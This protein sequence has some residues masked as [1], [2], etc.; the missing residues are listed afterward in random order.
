MMRVVS[1]LALVLFLCAPLRAQDGADKTLRGVMQSVADQ[2]GAPVQAIRSLA[3]G[4]ITK[5]YARPGQLV[6]AGEILAELDY[7]QQLYQRNTAKAQMDSEGGMQSAEGQ[8]SQRKAELE[9]ARDLLKKRVIAEYR[10]ASAEAWV[11]WAEGQ[12]KSI[13]EQK[14]QQK[15]AYE[16]WATEYEKRFIRAPLDGVITELKVSEGQGIG[17]AAHVFTQNNPSAMQLS[18]SVVAAQ[19]GN[20]NVNDKLLVRPPG[21]GKLMQAVVQ[22]VI[23]DPADPTKKIV[24]LLV[25]NRASGEAYKTG[26]F[27][28][29]LP[30]N[31]AAVAPA[32]AG[33]PAGSPAPAPQG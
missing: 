23:D 12:L 32:P 15:L 5:I 29:F 22:E 6:K 8:L 16:Y 27:D 25:G 24:R 33:L 19:M 31:P 11:R 14:E 18:T 3:P 28:V 21:G 10:V 2:A 26:Q 4:T 13:R 7:D 30:A 1:C 17:I 20:V 9:E